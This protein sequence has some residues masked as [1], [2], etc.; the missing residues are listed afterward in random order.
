MNAIFDFVPDF[1]PSCGDPLL[2]NK[3]KYAMQDY[4]GECAHS[5]TNCGLRFQFV[6]TD[7][8]LSIADDLRAHSND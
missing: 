7:R 1:C 2:P 4:R 6:P 3:D 8:L 5:C